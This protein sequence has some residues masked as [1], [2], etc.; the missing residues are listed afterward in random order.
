MISSVKRWKVGRVNATE[1]DAISGSAALGTRII[2][3]SFPIRR[4]SI[5]ECTGESDLFEVQSHEFRLSRN[6]KS[7]AQQDSVTSLGR[8]VTMGRL[9]GPRDT[10]ERF[11]SDKIELP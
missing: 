10:R 3:D 5:S 4:V 1:K 6:G 8:S 11:T 2:S 9:F 7:R